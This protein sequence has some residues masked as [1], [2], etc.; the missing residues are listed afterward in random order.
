MKVG[1]RVWGLGFSKSKQILKQI[2]TFP[3]LRRYL[4][5]GRNQIR[6]AEKNLGDE[7]SRAREKY[8]K[9]KTCELIGAK[10]QLI[11]DLGNNRI[12]CLS[13]SRICELRSDLRFSK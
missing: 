13:N 11:C 8:H 9:P 12:C 6:E 5:Q 1:Y 2:H 7:N 10:P 3:L 4:P